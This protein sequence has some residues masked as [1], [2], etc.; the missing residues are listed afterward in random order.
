MVL[1]LIVACIAGSVTLALARPSLA[2][3]VFRVLA[4]TSCVGWAVGLVL[5][6]RWA[7]P[8]EYMGEVQRIMYVHVPLL[9]T[10][11]L[12]LGL[13]FGAS[14][15]WLFL[16]HRTADELAGAVAEPGVAFGALGL[17]TGAIWGKATWGV[18]W[19]W[20]PRMISATAMVGLYAAYL[21]VR[22]ALGERARFPAAVM[23][24]SVSIVLPVVW[25]SVRWWSSLHQLQSNAS[26]MDPQMRLVLLA[27]VG[28]MFGVFTCLVWARLTQRLTTEPG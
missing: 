11:M 7:P 17:L 2:R 1:G 6:L 26:T 5:G 20:D 10:C 19:S 15:W 22:A 28:A 27:N 3:P 13:N 12:A 14:L 24:T 9:W 18:W 21:L 8:D 23:A 4:V 25:F 16:G